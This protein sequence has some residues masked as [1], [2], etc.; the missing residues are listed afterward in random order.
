MRRL[1]AGASRRDDGF[2]GLDTT[3]EGA[4]NGY[5]LLWDN[6][7][8]RLRAA[9]IS[10]ATITDLLPSARYEPTSGWHT[11]RIEAQGDQITFRIDGTLMTTVTDTTHPSGPCGVA[12]S[13]HFTGYPAD[14]GATFDNF[15]ADALPAASVEG[16][17]MY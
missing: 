17:E 16:W 9:R 5:A 10:E 8:G 7:D 14:R 2:A 3:Y 11:L 1:R 15:R 4:G 13:S 6:D 12:Y